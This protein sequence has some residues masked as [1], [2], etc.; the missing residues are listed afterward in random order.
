ME[1]IKT[2]GGALISSAMFKK[3]QTDFLNS[4]PDEFKLS[5]FR[6]KTLKECDEQLKALY[7]IHGKYKKRNGSNR[8]IASETEKAK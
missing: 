7:A 1:A 5:M 2:S 8:N 4:F 3:S 6:N